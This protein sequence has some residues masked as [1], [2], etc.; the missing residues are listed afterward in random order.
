[1]AMNEKAFWLRTERI[2]PLIVMVE[3]IWLLVICFILVRIITQSIGCTTL[4]LCYIVVTMS[5]CVDRCNIP[6]HSDIH[7]GVKVLIGSGK[8]EK[9]VKTV[10]FAGPNG[11]LWQKAMF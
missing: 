4:F 7:L 10:I 9:G 5:R 1:M 8:Q 11:F 3:P 2:Q 6:K